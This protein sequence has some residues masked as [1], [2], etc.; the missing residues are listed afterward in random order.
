MQNAEELLD[1]KGYVDAIDAISKEDLYHGINTTARATTLGPSRQASS[2]LKKARV[3]GK[4]VHVI[5]YL[6]GK[7][8]AEGPQ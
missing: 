1:D 6:D 4:G 3:A 8:A 7:A 2:Q 5:E